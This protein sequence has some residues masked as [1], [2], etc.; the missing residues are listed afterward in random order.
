[1][2]D[3]TANTFQEFPPMPELTPPLGLA[4]VSF[5][6]SSKWVAN[7]GPF[8]ASLVGGRT[9]Y[10]TLQIFSQTQSK[11]PADLHDI[12]SVHA[13]HLRS[14]VVQGQLKDSSV[15]NLCTYLERFECETIPSDELVAAIPRTIQAFAVTDTTP[16][17]ALAARVWRSL[18]S[19]AP[20]S[21]ISAAYLT[22]QLGS[23]PSLRVFRWMGS[24]AHPGFAAL[25]ERCG[26]LRIELHS[27]SVGC[28]FLIIHSLAETYPKSP[29]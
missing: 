8:V 10:E 26:S 29:G 1:M 18:G 16:D 9:D 17:S 11:I 5:K 3:I 14:L 2:L 22:E 25:R 27:N 19:A 24:T 28:S 23:F 4:L 6:F 13:P 21:Y 12:I 7:M 20:L 15:L